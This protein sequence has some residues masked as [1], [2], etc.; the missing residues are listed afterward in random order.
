M[1]KNITQFSKS[2]NRL[3]PLIKKA[4]WQVIPI[5]LLALCVNKSVYAQTGSTKITGTVSDSKGEK[6]IGVTVKVKGTAIA[7]ATDVNGSYAIS[8]IDKKSTLVFSYIGFDTKEEIVGD[9]KVINT[10]LGEGASNL[11]EVVVTGYGQSVKKS[12][13]VGSI[14]S[15][16][17]KQIQERQPTSLADALE[18]QLSGAQ[19]VTD[20]GDPLSQGTIQIRGASTLSAGNGPLYVIDGVLND[21]AAYLNP[22]DIASIEVLKD[23]ASAAIY[24]VRGANGVI[25]ITTKGGKEGKA[26]LN[27]NYYHLFGKLAHKLQTTSAK[28]LTYFRRVENGGAG[29]GAAVNPDSVSTF[30]N[31]DNDY[32]DLLYRTGNKDNVN[33]TVSGGSKGL[34]YYASANY[35]NDRSIIINSQA[36]SLTALFNVD[37]QA[38]TKFKLTNHIGVSYI[39]GNSVDVGSTASTVFQ[40]NP[41]VSLYRPDGSL[42]GYVESK[43]NP[44]AY[45]LLGE[46]VPT[47]YTVQDNIAATYQIYSDLKFTGSANARLD[48]AGR[49]TFIPLSITSGALGP[50]SGTTNVDNKLVYELQ[51]FFNYSKVFAKDHNVTAVAG[52]SRDHTRDDGYNFAFQNYLSEAVRV[53][54]AADQVS[55]GINTT[56]TYH[57]TE[58]MFAR[59]QYGYKDR[60]IIN[61]TFR[62]DG[63]SRFGDENKWG[64]FGAA[65]LAWRFSA[66]KFMNWSKSFLDDAKFR[67]SVGVLGN[68]KVNQ[69]SDFPYATLLNFGVGTVTTNT[70]IYNGNNGAYVSANLGNQTLKWEQTVT[71]NFGMDLSMFGGRLVITPEYYIKKTNG[72]L[73]SQTLPEETGER[74]A[75]INLGNISNHGFELT[76]SATPIT[77]KNFSWNTNFN[78]TFQNAGEITSLAPTAVAINGSYLI[79]QG[80]HIGDFYLLKNQGVYQ[81]DVSNAYD[82]AGNRLIPVGVNA[83]GTTATGYNEADGSAYGGTIHQLKRNGKTLI[84]GSTI[85]Q[86][87]NNDGIIDEN[88]RQVL[89]NAIPK[90]YWG[91]NNFFT[92]KWFTLNVLFNASFGN[93]NL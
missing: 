19:V 49:Q 26:R 24:G 31:Q 80:G 91:I 1:R 38:T 25:L 87:T 66:E 30:D 74:A 23:A 27:V 44:V 37:Y 89:G 16:S 36:H 69:S 65:G 3:L 52:F 56:S 35:F 58:S 15:V 93:K 71:Q 84:G 79:K 14:G 76:I 41:W 17:A 78:V 57:S 29:T 61:G 86:D 60:Y 55:T 90:T 82:V 2:C 10:K 47:T 46:N 83:T 75:A 73:A 88:D 42:A 32:Q 54:S 59:V 53:S 9:R 62:R 33:M 67:Y 72:L 22:Q 63:S 39:T 5:L 81:Y 92:Y 34:V 28:D 18:G 68:D 45:A 51:A 50:N 40:R 11:S 20:G 7:V 85:W 43:K 12:D 4:A 77:K 6:L 13:L 70:G 48:D 21:D 8:V 64:N